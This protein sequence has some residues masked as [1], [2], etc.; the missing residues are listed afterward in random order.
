[1]RWKKLGLIFESSEGSGWRASHASIPTPLLLD[2]G[3]VR[4][5]TNFQDTKGISRVGYLDLD[6]DEAGKAEVARVSAVPVLDIGAPG[7]FDE[8]GVMVCSVVRSE[9]GRLFMYYVGF[10]L[11]TKI[12]YRLLTGLAVSE[13]GGESFRR[14][15]QT[16]VLERS[17]SELYFRGG[18]FCRYENGVYR[19]WYVAGSAWEDVA[20]KQMP[21]YEVKYIESGD[22]INWPLSGKTVISISHKDEHGFGRPYVIQTPAGSWEMYYS[23]RRRSFGQY[24]MGYAVSPDSINWTRCD[25][26][27]NFDVSTRGFDSNAV[28]YA[29]P[30]ILGGSRVMF[31][32]GDQFG[33]D[34]VGMAVL[35]Q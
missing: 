33:R 1:M 26:A 5:Y 27:L 28:M 14:Y 19:M 17:N 7:T 16:P 10:E 4:L 2:S 29:A 11:G 6:I 35:E 15:R 22:G 34:G 12:R 32:N 20:G 8:N 30:I 24:R 21:V 13:D 23:I 3:L 25:D 31:Y 9:D 18:P